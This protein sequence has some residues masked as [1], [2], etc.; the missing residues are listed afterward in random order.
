MAKRLEISKSYYSELENGRKPITSQIEKKV[1]EQLYNR[2]DKDSSLIASLDWVSVHF[3]TTD[4]EALVKAILHLELNDFTLQDYSRYH[5]PYYFSYGGINLY[6]NPEDS[7]QGVAI[8]MSGSACRVFEVGLVEENRDWYDFFNDCLLYENELRKKQTSLEKQEISYFNVTRLDLALDEPY[9]EDG[10]YSIRDLH[11]RFEDHLVVSKKRTT[12]DISEK[13][14]V[15]GFT[16]YI[17]SQTSPLFFR[18]YEKDAERAKALG[19]TVDWIHQYYGIKNRYEI[20]MKG[21]QANQFIHDYLREAFD[22]AQRGVQIINGNMTVFSDFKGHLDEDWYDLM[23]STTAYRFQM[24]P[25]KIN[26]EK[27]WR[28]AKHSVFPTLKALQQADEKRFKSYLSTAQ[29]PKRYLQLLSETSGKGTESL[30]DDEV[31]RDGE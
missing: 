25:K 3:R 9:S 5:Y 14:K 29:I 7:V 11:Q 20:V 30:Q 16:F 10:N 22:L 13:G 21:H 8:E 23:N 19:T 26:W 27:T 4:A 17:G 2:S 18:F 6:L 28:W 12:K 15:E 24:A 1:K 31:G